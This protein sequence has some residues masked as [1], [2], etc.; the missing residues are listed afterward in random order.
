MND[1]VICLMPQ[2]MEACK[3]AYIL[4]LQGTNDFRIMKKNDN[5][6]EVIEELEALIR[7]GKIEGVE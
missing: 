4:L 1:E 7:K 5:I 2:L 6:Y 3:K